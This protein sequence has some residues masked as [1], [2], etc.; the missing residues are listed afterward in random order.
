[1][2]DCS[3]FR[4]IWIGRGRLPPHLGRTIDYRNVAQL[5]QY[6]RLDAFLTVSKLRPVAPPW[7]GTLFGIPCRARPPQ[8]SASFNGVCSRTL[9]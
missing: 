1:M 7:T 6:R 8:P 3:E 5:W 4:V 9:Q 2:M